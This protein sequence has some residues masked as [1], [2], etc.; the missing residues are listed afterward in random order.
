MLIFFHTLYVGKNKVH[1]MQL[2]CSSYL[3]IFKDSAF[4]YKIFLNLFFSDYFIPVFPPFPSNF[5]SGAY[6]QEQ[7]WQTMSFDGWALN[8]FIFRSLN[9]VNVTV[10]RY[11]FFLGKSFRCRF[12]LTEYAVKCHRL[13]C[14]R[15]KNKEKTN[16]F[17]T[18]FILIHF[19]KSFVIHFLILTI[20]LF[21]LLIFVTAFLFG[22]E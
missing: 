11:I 18:I 17:K 15:H 22:T 7:H 19:M 10:A 1:L 3:D 14:K 6:E 5:P 21:I 20:S 13:W 16:K 8:T 2:W 4:P 12:N 9:V